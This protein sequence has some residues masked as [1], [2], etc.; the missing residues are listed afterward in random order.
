MK[1]GAESDLRALFF[2]AVAG[3][4]DVA[5]AQQGDRH[6]GGEGDQGGKGRIGAGH[7]GFS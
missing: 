5:D 6:K 1:T 4:S 7:D 3:R 2:A